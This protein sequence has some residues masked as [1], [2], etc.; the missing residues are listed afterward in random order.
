MRRL[1]TENCSLF[2][3]PLCMTYFARLPDPPYHAERSREEEVWPSRNILRLAGK[4]RTAPSLRVLS[5]SSDRHNL[6]RN[7]DDVIFRRRKAT[8]ISAGSFRRRIPR[9]VTRFL[10]CLAQIGSMATGAKNKDVS[11]LIKFH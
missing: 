1:R 5:R 10:S 8:R 6:H 11:S 2:P 4:P 3:P 7:Y 9:A